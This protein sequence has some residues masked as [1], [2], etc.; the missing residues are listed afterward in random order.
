[1][2]E[3][4]QPSKSL[5]PTTLWAISCGVIMIAVISGLWM[6]GGP[7][8]QRARRMDEHRAR[9][10]AEIQRLLA[11][12]Y[13]TRQALP[14]TLDALAGPELENFR[15]DPASG[16]PYTY[17]KTGVDTFELCANFTTDTTRDRHRPYETPYGDAMDIH[18]SGYHCFPMKKG[19]ESNRPGD[20]IRF[21]RVAYP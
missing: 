1:M 18:P 14:D 15:Q 8:A 4:E 12:Y 17:R 21:Q 16:K 6:T 2:T 20:F 11:D 9:D 13:Q 10:L 19:P 3:R 5:L 7:M